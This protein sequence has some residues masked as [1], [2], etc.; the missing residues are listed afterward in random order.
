MVYNLNLMC[1]IN[2]NIWLGLWFHFYLYFWWILHSYSWFL[3]AWLQGCW[4]WSVSR[5]F[6]GKKRATGPQRISSG[7]TMRI[8]FVYFRE[9][10]VHQQLLERLPWWTLTC[11]QCTF[12]QTTAMLKHY[13][14]FCHNFNQN[15]WL[16]EGQK[17]TFLHKIHVCVTKKHVWRCSE[18]SSKLSRGVTLTN[19]ETSLKM[20]SLA[21]QPSLLCGMQPMTNVNISVICRSVTC[22]HFI[23]ASGLASVCC[24][25]F[26]FVFILL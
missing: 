9:N 15:T 16:G 12:L 17:N 18:V 11:W 14:S 25:V 20:Q 19:V 7:A 10:T 3:A 22:Q 8:T 1:F 4:C 2:T 6:W 21:W 23:L 13:I 26:C 24:R 5:L